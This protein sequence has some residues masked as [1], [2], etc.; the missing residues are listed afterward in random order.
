MWPKFVR[1]AS[2]GLL[3]VS[4][5]RTEAVKRSLFADPV[6]IALYGA[7]FLILC[8]IA[9]FWFGASVDWSTLRDPLNFSNQTFEPDVPISGAIADPIYISLSMLMLVFA[10]VLVAQPAHSWN[11]RVSPSLALWGLVNIV[12]ATTVALAVLEWRFNLDDKWIYYRTSQNI[13]L[14]GVPN[15]NAG[16][17]FNINT[18]FLYPYLTLP[19]HFFGDFRSWEVWTKI[20]GFTFHVATGIMI[21]IVFG[22]SLSAIVTASAYLLYIPALLWSLGGL[23]TPIATFA[24]VALILFYLRTNPHSLCF[25]FCCG[26]MMWLRPDAILIGI[27]VFALQFWLIPRPLSEY[28]LKG[29]IFSAPI[30]IF[31][32]VNQLFFGHPMPSPFYVKGWNKAFSGIY[33]WYVDAGVGAI[34]LIS[35]LLVSFLVAVIVAYGGRQ[36]V[37]I[38]KRGEVNRALSE[39]DY[40]RRHFCALAGLLLFL[41]YHVMAGYQHMNFTFRYFIPGIL[42]L[43][44][45]FSDFLVRTN[46]K[47]WLG[48]DALTPRVTMLAI[49]FQ[50]AQSSFLAYHVKWYDLALTDSYLRDRFSVMSLSQAMDVWLEAG[51]FLRTITKSSDRIWVVQGLATS[52]LTKSYLRDQFYAPLKW[53]KFADLRSCQEAKPFEDCVKLF[54]YVVTF[55]RA[56]AIPEGFKPVK[57]YD[58]TAPPGIQILQRASVPQQ[59]NIPSL[60]PPVTTRPILDVA[61]LN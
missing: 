38:L 50:L 60:V 8:R 23:E 3:F 61:P 20:L 58:K 17:W 26:A 34:H 5:F 19:G 27:G 10:G 55:T 9:P 12:I 43:L 52:A 32:A 11:A 30:A 36:M 57:L 21:F 45:V 1:S 13:L 4:R 16:E 31:F 24:V 35:G 25:W 7:A 33:P 37:R 48:K 56:S 47:E 54:D 51:E 6:I 44:V 22:F 41:A 29:V 49:F 18:S 40:H 14:D 2:R 59:P 15:Y 39:T 42:G 46:G 28:F 53:S